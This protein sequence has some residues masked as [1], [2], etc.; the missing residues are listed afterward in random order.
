MTT[1]AKVASAGRD[2][3]LLGRVDDTTSLIMDGLLLRLQ[4]V[5]RDD[6]LRLLSL[7]PVRLLLLE[8]P[9]AR[10]VNVLL[11]DDNIGIDVG[12]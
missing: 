12:A 8:R 3:L 11:V 10:C 5:L 2:D 7:A 4:A 6:A 1:D 9:C